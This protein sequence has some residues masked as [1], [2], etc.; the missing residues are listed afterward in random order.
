M[1][2]ISVLPSSFATFA[3]QETKRR[4]KTT[5]GCILSFYIPRADFSTNPN[6]FSYIPEENNSIDEDLFFKFL[7]FL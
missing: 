6:G 1:C 4:H 3:G 7:K 2:L 5:A